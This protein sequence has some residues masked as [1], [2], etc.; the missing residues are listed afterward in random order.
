M[1][2][3]IVTE[4]KLTKTLQLEFIGVGKFDGRPE[5]LGLASKWKGRIHH[6]CR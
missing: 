1:M 3:V 5:V 6:F 4:A 2:F